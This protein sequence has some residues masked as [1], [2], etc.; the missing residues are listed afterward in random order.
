M[1]CHCTL[2]ELLLLLLLQ[3]WSYAYNQGDKSEFGGTATDEC[4]SDVFIWRWSDS[5]Q[6]YHHGKEAVI[7]TL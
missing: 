2:D 3:W 1:R 4:V 7:V 6:L 5:P